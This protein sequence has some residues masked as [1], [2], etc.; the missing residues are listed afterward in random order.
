MRT[1]LLPAH[2]DGRPVSELLAGTSSA[3]WPLLVFAAVLGAM[4]GSWGATLS[5]VAPRDG[6][7][8]WTRP[9]CEGCGHRPV[10]LAGAPIVRWLTRHRC[11]ACGHRPDA[12]R[13]VFEVATSAVFVAAAASAGAGWHLPALWYLLWLTLTL[14]VIDIDIRRLPDQIVLPGYALSAAALVLAHGHDPA[15]L[16]RAALGAVSLGLLYGVIIVIYPAGMGFGDVK[17]APILGAYLGAT[18]W[19]ALG[20]GAVAG[21]AVGGVAALVLLAVRRGRHGPGVPFGPAML[22]GTWV[23][24]VAGQQ[25]WEL[26]WALVVGR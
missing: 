9:A 18:S 3:P 21:F 16:G 7:F 5:F 23:A 10:L 11:V 1:F 15:A 24:L 12:R 26:Y 2:V 4:A 13:A 19:A 22:A 8:T 25:L 17:L 20:V 14:T 6:T